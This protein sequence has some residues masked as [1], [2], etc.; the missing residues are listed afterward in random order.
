MARRKQRA[1]LPP[2]G[3]PTSSGRISIQIVTVVDGEK[4]RLAHSKVLPSE[5]KTYANG[6]DAWDGYDR[7]MAHLEKCSANGETLRSFWARWIDP[8]HHWN[9][10]RSESTV[11]TYESRTRS[12]VAFRDYADLPLAAFTE[13]H[14]DIFREHGGLL[15]AVGTI[16]RIFMD[17]KRRKLITENPFATAAAEAER[18]IEHRQRSKKRKNPPPSIPQIDATLDRLRTGPYPASLL[19]WLTAGTETGARGGEIDAMEWEYLDEDACEYDIQW[20]WHHKL[21]AL[22]PPK[23]GSER[24]VG[25]S[26]LVM[27]QIARQRGNG[28]RYIWTDPERDH[29]THATRGYWWEWDADGGPTLRS[30][31]GGATMYRATRHHWASKALNVLG[32]SPYQASLLYGHSDGGKLL[33]ETYATGDHGLAVKNATAAANRMRATVVDLSTRRAA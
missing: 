20:Q 12:F 14:L 16:S 29:W 33:V 7:V 13:K 3:R 4:K 22:T 27:S 2:G 32:I 31:A 17:A 28:S 6:S 19:G 9:E 5:P 30:L 15:S 18:L 8:E 26:D 11:L 21:N 24:V 10:R 23:H 25:L 1:A